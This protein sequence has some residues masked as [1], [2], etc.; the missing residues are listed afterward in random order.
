MPAGDRLPSDVIDMI[1]SSDTV[2]LGT[3]FSASVD[4]AR[5]NPSHVGINHRGGRPGF[6]RVLPDG[7]SIVIPDYSG[8]RLMTCEYKL[9]R[10]ILVDR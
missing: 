4:E 5:I 7:R 3:Y 9:L 2:F 10:I 8:N 1:T 6:V